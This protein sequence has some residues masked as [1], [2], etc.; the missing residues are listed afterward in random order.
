MSWSVPKS[1]ISLKDM[2]LLATPSKRCSPAW[3]LSK[4]TWRWR[5]AQKIE[6]YTVIQSHTW[7]HWTETKQADVFT[8]SWVFKM[9]S[10]QVKSLISPVTWSSNGSSPKAGMYLAHSTNTSNCCLIESQ[11]SPTVAAF[12]S[13]I[14]TIPTGDVIWME[15]DNQMSLCLN[16][17]LF[18]I[19]LYSDIVTIKTVSR[20]FTEVQ[21]PK[22][23]TVAAKTPINRKKPWSGAG[24]YGEE[25]SR[26]KGRK[27]VG[28]TH[29]ATHTNISG[30]RVE[31]ERVSGVKGQQV[32]YT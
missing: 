12:C 19:H 17:F 1:R 9:E 27:R 31:S 5:R 32:T 23:A 20:C 6:R 13:D 11:M 18:C 15:T 26:E 21:S 28:E 24:S 10:Y 25:R 22:H 8:D 29:A 14:S 3:A 30:C 4:L 7:K 16:P 2:D